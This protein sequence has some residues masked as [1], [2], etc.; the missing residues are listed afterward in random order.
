MSEV[1]QKV[2]QGKLTPADVKNSNKV[3]QNA[4]QTLDELLATYESDALSQLKKKDLRH[5]FANASS[6][7]FSFG[8]EKQTYK[9]R[10]I[11]LN[12]QLT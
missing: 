2:A 3:L 11:K 9:A 1:T 5:N 10:I 8:D 6:V 4:V 12:S 7:S